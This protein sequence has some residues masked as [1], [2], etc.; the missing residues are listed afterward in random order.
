MVCTVSSG[1]LQVTDYERYC[2]SEL[3]LTVAREALKLIVASGYNGPYDS[4]HIR[5]SQAIKTLEE[6]DKVRNDFK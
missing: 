4:K 1:G 6:M 5:A 2:H 3:M